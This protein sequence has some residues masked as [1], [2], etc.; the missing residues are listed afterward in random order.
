MLARNAAFGSQ[1]SRRRDPH[2]DFGGHK[3]P[4]V[5]VLHGYGA[6]KQGACLDAGA[7]RLGGQ[8]CGI[9]QPEISRVERL[10]DRVAGVAERE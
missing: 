6:L 10:A 1:P 5:A 3:E 4:E 8:M 2:C 7:R 9:R